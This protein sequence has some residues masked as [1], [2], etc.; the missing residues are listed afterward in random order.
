MTFEEALRWSK[1]QY[2]PELERPDIDRDAVYRI[3]A[4]IE[5]EGWLEEN[6]Q[7]DER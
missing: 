4:M 5:L 7:E 6:E 1:A 3:H 2:W